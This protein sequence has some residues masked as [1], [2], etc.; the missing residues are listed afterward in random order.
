LA[1]EEGIVLKLQSPTTALVKTTKSSACEGCASKQSCNSTGTG[2]EMEV[3]VINPA[4]AKEGDKVVIEFKSS[5]LLKASFLIHIFPILCLVAGA[6]VGQEV[7]VK[8]SLDKS[9]T[10][11]IF[12]F[13]F[14]LLAFLI[15]RLVGE[16]MA[17]KDSYK[18]RII[19]VKNSRR[20]GSAL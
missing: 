7:A 3:E 5:S 18:P 11:A 4:N 1:T 10:S 8:F 9:A 6:I 14:F 13:L 16:K 19:R 17:D 12:G 20:Q 2:K 15:V